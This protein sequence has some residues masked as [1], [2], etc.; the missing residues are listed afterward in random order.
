MTSISFEKQLEQSFNFPSHA[1]SESKKSKCRIF[2][3]WKETSIVLNVP[4]PDKEMI[5]Y[6][7]KSTTLRNVSATVWSIFP[8]HDQLLVEIPSATADMT[9]LQYQ[10]QAWS[11]MLKMKMTFAWQLQQHCPD[12]GMY[13]IRSPDVHDCRTHVLVGITIFLPSDSFESAAI[14][15]Q[16]YCLTHL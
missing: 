4:T 10:V 12:L 9:F 1:A 14:K 11:L 2:W 7:H 5:T 16:V 3:C 13:A 8:L 15:L 6:W